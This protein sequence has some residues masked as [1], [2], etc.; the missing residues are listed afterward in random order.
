MSIQV[1]DIVKYSGN[2]YLVKSINVNLLALRKIFGRTH[3][4]VVPSSLILTKN[5]HRLA[6]IQMFI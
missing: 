3:V 1:N 4:V 2:Y 5:I 6:V